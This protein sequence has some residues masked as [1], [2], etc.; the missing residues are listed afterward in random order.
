MA[1][2]S[3]VFAAL[4]LA[5]AGLGVITT[6]IPVLGAVFSFG[7]PA[8]A[9]AGVVMGGVA[10]SRGKRARTSTDAA[11]A[12]VIF[13]GLCFVPAL[14]TALTCGVCN[15][16]WSGG[17]IEARRDFHF[18]VQAGTPRQGA[19]PGQPGR[20]PEPPSQRPGATPQPDQPPAAAPPGAA[21]PPAFPPPPIQQ[22]RAAPEEPQ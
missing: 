14:L 21:P 16:L 19:S 22:P 10:M 15:A 11:V 3:I 6:P 18:D 5:C 12:G 20:A 8:L 7:A 1:V 13:N 4:A 17:K 2:G 9:L